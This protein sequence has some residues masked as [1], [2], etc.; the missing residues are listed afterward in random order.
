MRFA[1]TSIFSAAILFMVCSGNAQAQTSRLVINDAMVIGEWQNEAQHMA[2]HC[3]PSG[4]AV[5]ELDVGIEGKT[6]RVAFG[7]YRQVGPGR[8]ELSVKDT[9]HKTHVLAAIFD[10]YHRLLVHK[11]LDEPFSFLRSGRRF[12]D[13][14]RDGDGWIT[15]SEAKGSPLIYHYNEFATG[16]DRQVDRAAYERFLEKYPHLGSAK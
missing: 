4:Q 15:K 12:A 5:L 11:G 1:S 13:L 8:W 7:T 3:F 9:D 10:S 16:K 14:D 6:P 2:L